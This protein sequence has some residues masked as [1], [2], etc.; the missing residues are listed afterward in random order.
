MPDRVEHCGMTGRSEA[1]KGET[2]Q[3]NAVDDCFNVHSAVDRAETRQSPAG[4]PGS[5][6]V[7][8]DQL[9]T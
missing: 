9:V 3:A 7:V 2:T 6:M 8:Q 4:K 1:Q 5:P